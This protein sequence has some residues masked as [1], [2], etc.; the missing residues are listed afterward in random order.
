M[1][2]IIK[3]LVIAGL[4]F[5]QGLEAGRTNKKPVGKPAPVVDLK[6]LSLHEDLFSKMT[7]RTNGAVTKEDI[8]AM[9]EAKKIG[10]IQVASL[11]GAVTKAINAGNVDGLVQSLARLMVHYTNDEIQA[12]GGALQQAL[13]ALEAAGKPIELLNGYVSNFNELNKTNFVYVSQAAAEITPVEEEAGA[14][15]ALPD[16]VVDGKKLDPEQAINFYQRNK[17]YFIAAGITAA[18]ATTGIA[19]WYFWPTISGYIISTSAYQT[20]CVAGSW[21]GACADLAAVPGLQKGLVASEAAH[22]ETKAALATAEAALAA[23]KEWASGNLTALAASE[24]AH[25]ATAAA[26]AAHKALRAPTLYE[27]ASLAVGQALLSVHKSF[28]G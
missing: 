16:V 28:F 17:K 27:H 25:D 10:Q 14:P 1:K 19:V 9:L 18:V 3:T 7:V 24:A 5:V 2:R 22:N 6:K 26:F 12:L 4:L 20:T 11:K 15:E 13:A 8:V 23:A 21:G